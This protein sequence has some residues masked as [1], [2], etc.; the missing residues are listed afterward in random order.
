[1]KEISTS[2]ISI[3]SLSAAHDNPIIQLKATERPPRRE[4]IWND[5][6]LSDLPLSYI[7]QNYDG[8]IF[9]NDNVQLPRHFGTNHIGYQHACNCKGYIREEITLTPDALQ[10][11]VLIY[12]QPSLNERCGMCGALLRKIIEEVNNK[13]YS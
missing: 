3:T 5:L 13:L 6:G 9:N 11:M 4:I 1:M 10:N 2:N 7:Y 12:Q 8:L